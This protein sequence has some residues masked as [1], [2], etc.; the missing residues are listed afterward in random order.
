MCPRPTDSSVPVPSA[1]SGGCACGAVRYD[2]SA[3]PIAMVNCHCRD[4]QKAGGGAYS[5]TVVVRTEAVHVTL[6]EPA[7]HHV[8]ADSGHIARRAFCSGCGAPLYASTSA[9]PDV[10]G[11]RA[12]SLDDP[13][14]F[15]AAADVWT[16]SAPPWDIMD[17]R[18]PKFPKDR[19]QRGA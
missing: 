2:C 16:E 3:A 5:P 18:V 17:P 10:L 15:R 11:I 9:R 12:G 4:C 13:R 6:G 14:W 7:Y 8:T 1:F 19:M